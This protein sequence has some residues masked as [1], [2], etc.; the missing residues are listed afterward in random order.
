VI[1]IVAS[2]LVDI[3]HRPAV[4]VALNETLSQGSA[5]SVAGF[6]LYEAIKACSEG[7]ISFGGHAAAAGLRLPGRQFATFARQF[8]DHCRATLTAEQRQRVLA[9]DAEVPLGVLTL[10]VVEEIESLEPYGSGNPRPLLAANHVRVVGEPRLVGERKNHVQL[11]LVQGNL[12]LKA[13]AW[14]MADRCKSLKADSL[15]S[16]AFHPAVN[17][18]N[19]R[20][21]VQLEIRDLILEGP[22]EVESPTP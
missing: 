16:I 1:G 18:W 19:N 12:S 17:E 13:I 22:G 9:I 8:D 5:R 15:C 14:N 20:R 3:Y 21:E 10:R 6:D 4:V 2:R 11:R 7:L